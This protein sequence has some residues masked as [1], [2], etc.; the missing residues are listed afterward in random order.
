MK[1]PFLLL[2][3]LFVG[4][5]IFA[6]PSNVENTQNII[7]K[8]PGNIN[9]PKDLPKDI[10]DAANKALDG[11]GGGN[12]GNPQNI[13]DKLPGNINIPKDIKDA[14]S[15]ALD[16]IGGGNFGGIGIGGGKEGKSVGESQKSLQNHE[17]INA[18]YERQIDTLK[19]ILAVLKENAVSDRELLFFAKQRNSL[20]HNKNAIFATKGDINEKNNM[21]DILYGNDDGGLCP[22]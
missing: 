9:I 3:F 15:K 12:F 1:Q 20:I 19:R 22:F 5:N 14:A 18:L 17:N 2:A 21:C 16:G 7:D 8:L 10:K 11:I 4:M 6:N 13:I